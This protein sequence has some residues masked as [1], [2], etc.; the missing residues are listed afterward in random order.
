MP[1]R[2]KQTDISKKHSNRRRSR[3]QI[4]IPFKKER[5]LQAKF[6]IQLYQLIRCSYRFLVLDSGDYSANLKDPGKSWFAFGVRV[7]CIVISFWWLYKL[8]AF[9]QI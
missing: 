3:Q 8:I 4:L 5:F 7:G 2:P 1:E 6:G 9:L